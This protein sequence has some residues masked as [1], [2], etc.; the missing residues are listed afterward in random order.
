MREKWNRFDYLCPTNDVILD[1]QIFNKGSV[2]L[3][4]V[5]SICFFAHAWF[6]V[7]A[8]GEAEELA[9]FLG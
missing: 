7:A 1:H 9:F 4:H 3:R 6:A 5:F 8:D 2:V